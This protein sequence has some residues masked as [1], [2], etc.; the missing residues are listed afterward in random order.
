MVY[1]QNPTLLELK[2]EC[3]KYCYVKTFWGIWGFPEAWAM[4]T[5]PHINRFL[6]LQILK[7]SLSCFY[8]CWQMKYGDGF[9]K[10]YTVSGY[11]IRKMWWW[12]YVFRKNIYVGTDR[13]ENVLWEALLWSC[14]G[15][16]AL[17]SD[18]EIAAIIAHPIETIL[19][20]QTDERK[21]LITRQT[22]LIWCIWD[23]STALS[24]AALCL[25]VNDYCPSTAAHFLSAL[26]SQ[27]Q[28]VVRIL[29]WCLRLGK[30]EV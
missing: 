15:S 2:P 28:Q 18:A 20:H 4:C 1:A 13:T 3:F 24:S 27:H 29:L 25:T 12:W 22:P 16:F 6:W 9:K 11:V 26:F 19:T 21:S 23:S 30:K 14:N 7:F 17:L 10:S 8:S 5:W